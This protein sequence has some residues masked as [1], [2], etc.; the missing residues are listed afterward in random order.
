M[1]SR[2]MRLVLQASISAIGSMVLACIP[3]LMELQKR[4]SILAAHLRQWHF[5]QNSVL[6]WGKLNNKPFPLGVNYW[7]YL[8][9]WPQN[10]WLLGCFMVN[11]IIGTSGTLMNFDVSS[12]LRSRYFNGQKNDWHVWAKGASMWNLRR[13]AATSTYFHLHLCQFWLCS[14]QWHV[15]AISGYESG[16]LVEALQATYRNTGRAS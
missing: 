1:E 7:V 5:L 4:D 2:G 12:S 13:L 10:G 8:Y 9:K 16:A 15:M 11:H 14:W 6:S 3:G